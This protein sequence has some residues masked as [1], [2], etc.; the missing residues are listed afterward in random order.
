MHDWSERTGSRR[1]GE[2]Y[3]GGYRLC[4]RCGIVPLFGAKKYC[5]TCFPIHLKERIRK[6]LEAR[7]P[8]KCICC[9]KLFHPRTGDSVRRQNRFCS[10][11]CGSKTVRPKRKVKCIRCGLVFV[12]KGRGWVKYCNK[13]RRIVHKESHLRYCIKTGK[14]KNPGI[15]S[16]GAQWGKDNPF[17][18][19]GTSRWKKYV[20]NFRKRCFKHWK[21]ACV[22][23]DSRKR[24]AVHHI[25][26]DGRST[27]QQNLVPLC[28]KHHWLVHRKRWTKSSEYEEAL[29]ALWPDGRSKIAEKFGNPEM[30]IRGEGHG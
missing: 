26:G 7:P 28:F 18:K 14:N 29:F 2:D 12:F 6:M 11:S 4:L 8:H 5:D 19:G 25:D 22:I 30:G 24:I 1:R 10:R 17:W 20:G 15:G 21:R 27:K 16:G 23:C 3:E 13:C 9:G